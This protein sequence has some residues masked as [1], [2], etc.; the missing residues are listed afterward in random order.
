MQDKINILSDLLQKSGLKPTQKSLAFKMLSDIVT[1]YNINENKYYN[2]VK[3]DLKLK[4]DFTEY[5]DRVY[6][7]LKLMGIS[8]LEVFELNY[9]FVDWILTAIKHN[10]T[11]ENMSYNTIK[12]LEYYLLIFET[13]Y[14]RLPTNMP[15]L[16][17]FIL[18]SI[19][20]DTD[21]F[22][23]EYKKALDVLRET[24]QILP[25]LQIGFFKELQGKLIKK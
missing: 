15:E 7:L 10:E 8:E 1:N 20:T 18:E 19:E 25:I 17:K 21:D 9:K 12:Q 6:L 14:N 16:K 24:K 13:C 11:A 5:F 23:S 3:Q 22:D 4:K 2:R